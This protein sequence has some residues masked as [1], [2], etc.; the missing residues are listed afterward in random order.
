MCFDMKFSHL[1][2]IN[3]PLSP[4]IEPLTCDQLWQGLVLRAE[5]PMRFVPHLDQ[6]VLLD[7]SGDSLQRELRYGT[8]VVRDE[9][10]FSPRH[11]VRYEV[12]AQQDIPASSL[13]MSI[14][15]PQ[16]GLL[17][18]RFDYEDATP[19]LANSMDAFYNEFRRSAYQESDIDTIRIIRQLADEGRFDPL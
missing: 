18:V 13:T 4:L 17:V 8:L 15:E 5:E 2:V 1:I 16:E 6:C 12:P 11:E 19:D 7:R 3:D 10:K 9:V 14:G